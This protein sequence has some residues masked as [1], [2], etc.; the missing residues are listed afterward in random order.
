MKIFK[1]LFVFLIP[2][3]LVAQEISVSAKLLTVYELVGKEKYREALT[4]VDEIIALDDSQINAYIFGGLCHKSLGNHDSADTYFVKA[5]EIKPQL[6]DVQFLKAENY[7]EAG[8]LK[9][10]DEAVEKILYYDNNHYKAHILKA[11]IYHRKGDFIEAEKKLLMV[12]NKQHFNL[13]SRQLLADLYL[14]LADTALALN[15]I[16]QAIIINPLIEEDL[17]F[18]IGI[19]NNLKIYPALIKDLNTYIPLVN[20]DPNMYFM[21][22]R[23]NLKTGD[24]ISALRDF[25]EVLHYDNDYAKAYYFRAIARKSLFDI[26]GACRDL[27]EAEKRNFL[28]NPALMDSFCVEDLMDD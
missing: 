1:F 27:K 22:G 10:A 28:P 6:T 17:K 9:A 12:M 4:E 23:A 3:S 19:L 18:R 20:N 15:V 24:T 2:A 13:E 21:R 8:D 16:S 26:E 5:L 7:F 14:E 11:K 25:N